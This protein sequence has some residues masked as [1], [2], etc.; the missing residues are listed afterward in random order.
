MR[1]MHRSSEVETLGPLCAVVLGVLRPAG[2]FRAPEQ[3]A[4]SHHA[5]GDCEVQGFTWPGQHFGVR[6][7]FPGETPISWEEVHHAVRHGDL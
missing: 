1:V 4:G 7:P 5:R 2:D 3:A 6:A